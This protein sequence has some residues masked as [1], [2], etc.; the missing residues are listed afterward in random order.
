M[1]KRKVIPQKP[2]YPKVFESFSEPW[3]IDA[4]ARNEPSAFN[5][6]VHV[7]IYRTT[8]ELVNEPIEVI[9]ER[10]EK[11]WLICDNWHNWGPLQA[12]AKEYRYTFKG[13]R[14]SQK[15]IKS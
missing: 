3:N 1:S 11:L 15:P 12:A 5:G 14:G 4:Y 7:R 9:H 6:G 10:L 8:V 2:K 13:E